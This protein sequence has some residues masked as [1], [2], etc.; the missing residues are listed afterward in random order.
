MFTTHTAVPAGH[1]H[2]PDDMMTAYFEKLCRDLKL[3]RDEFISLGK[4]DSAPEFNM[5]ALAL[6][7]SRFHNGVSNIHGGVSSRICRNLWPQIDPEENPMTFVTNGVH[8]PTFLSQEWAEL[9]DRVLG[10]EWRNNLCDAEFWERIHK[11]P[12]HLFWSV[13][14]SL[15]AQMLFLVRHRVGNQHFR[16]HG[17]EA[18]LDR[19]LRYTD[20]ESPNVLTVGFARRFA[21]YKRAALLFEN[22]DWLKEIMADEKRPVLFLFA[23]K[24][25][26]ADIPGQDLIRRV[27]E[28]SRMPEFEGK[29]L[30]LEGYDLHMAR[31]LVSGVDV[32]L[33]NPI[34]PLEASGTSGMKAGINGV[35]NLS[36]LDGW[37]GEGYDGKNGWAI[38]PGPENMDPVRR[39]RE[40][41]RTL[42][43]ILQDHVIPLY[44]ERG[45]MGYS[46][47]WVRMAK[48]S[49]ASLMPR[50]N[51]T[52]MAGEYVTRFYAGEPAGRPIRRWRPRHRPHHR[53]VEDA[54]APSLARRHGAPAGFIRQAHPIRGLAAHRTGGEV[55]RAQA[56]G[57]GGGDAVL[58]AGE[59]RAPVGVRALPA[60]VY[61]ERESGGR[62]YF[63]AAAQAGS[64]RQGGIPHPGLSLPRGAYSSS[65]DGDDDLAVKGP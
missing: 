53:P 38:K 11:V 42:Y 31:R 32:W 46:P 25:H 27:A 12:D 58:P 63:L 61:G 62:A 55:E 29:L 65:R 20:P 28:I 7:G 18:H 24:A 8:V 9:F 21:T 37:W 17:S 35:I 47:G 36:V 34:Y 22:L 59:E 5:T 56:R 1:D 64:L 19:M 23:G 40:E 13:R 51:S 60:R 39:N 26:P 2:F 33:N 45:T 54:G 16:N 50:F 49:I 43:E 3:G 52:R 57:R 15:K 4:V 30:L 48:H 6:R 10:N 14:Q 44:Y 41:S